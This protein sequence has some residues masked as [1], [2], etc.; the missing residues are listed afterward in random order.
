MLIS[1]YA[2]LHPNFRVHF[3]QRNSH[4]PHCGSHIHLNVHP[5][6]F[7]SVC[8]I[9]P[10]TANNSQYKLEGPGKAFNRAPVIPGGGNYT[11]RGDERTSGR[12]D[13]EILVIDA[14]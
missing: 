13:R 7:G 6:T 5:G 11:E 10:N 1:D 2:H 8:A 12:D 14:S 9:C 3:L 4:L